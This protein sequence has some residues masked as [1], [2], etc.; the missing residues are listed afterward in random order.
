MDIFLIDL[1]NL[2]PIT[3]LD[4]EWSWKNLGPSQRGNRGNMEHFLK[5]YYLNGHKYR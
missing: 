5:L 3:V 1:I 2:V 4:E